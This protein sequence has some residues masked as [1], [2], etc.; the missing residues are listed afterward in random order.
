MMKWIKIIISWL[1]K[2][3][4]NKKVQKTVFAGAGLGLGVAA[5]E[6][7]VAY[8]RNKKAEKIKQRAIEK[9]DKARQEIQG[10]LDKLGKNKLEVCDSFSDLADM[11][12]N[13]Q[14]RPEFK[15]T[16][17]GIE[18]PNFKPS[19]FKRLA[20]AVEM[21]IGGAGGV[22]AG[23]A[24]GAAVMGFNMAALGPGA[25]GG[26]VVLCVMAAKMM[27]RAAERVEQAQ[28][29][30]ADVEKIIRF[31]NELEKAVEKYNKAFSD[32]RKPYEK[33]LQKMHKILARK[34]NWE[35]FSRKEKTIVENTVL[36][37][38]MLC[39]MCALNLTLEATKK[40]P[41]ERVNSIEIDHMIDDVKNL[42][43]EVA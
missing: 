26:S 18:L 3:I 34:N 36:L 22:A 16:V 24:V 12:E 35:S 30:E 43:K 37:A 33:Q 1:A 9:H 31:Y 23:G 41:I 6:G 2:L 7:V 4:K 19:E 25:L 5:G 17:E 15:L 40:D 10:T 11:I 13:I 8:K 20:A 32:V 28:Q 39:R 14:Q 27:G 38:Q 29:I 42:L 21:A